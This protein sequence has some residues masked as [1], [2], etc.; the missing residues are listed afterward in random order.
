MKRLRLY[1]ELLV[2]AMN[3][4]VMHDA[5]AIA[6]HIALSVLT[7]FFPFLIL[8]TA[9]AGLFGTGSLADEVADITLEAWP[10][11][12]SGPI[13][14]EVHNILTG[15][16]SEGEWLSAGAS[17]LLSAYFSLPPEVQQALSDLTR[18]LKEQMSR[19]PRPTLHGRAMEYRTDD[20]A[21]P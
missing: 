15:R 20:S 19:E 3:R 13:A 16:R 18:S 9:L 5:W 1:A 21:A 6:S 7:S 17:E 8:V 4:F 12:I 2:I 11:E 10:K 14:G